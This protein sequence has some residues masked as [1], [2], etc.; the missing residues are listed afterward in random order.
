[1]RPFKDFTLS[2][3]YPALHES[4]PERHPC[5]H[6]I[7]LSAK[8]SREWKFWHKSSVFV[9]LFSTGYY[10]IFAE[11][12]LCSAHIA[13][14]GDLS[15]LVCGTNWPTSEGPFELSPC[16]RCASCMDTGCSR[17]AI[18][19]TLRTPSSPRKTKFLYKEIS[20]L[21]LQS[22]FNTVLLH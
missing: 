7:P 9:F 1:M 21:L 17:A 11:P 18:G 3:K 22:F 4:P 15:T 14:C 19:P 8:V 20:Y 12:D 2:K 5:T 16:W 10:L 6:H 13:L